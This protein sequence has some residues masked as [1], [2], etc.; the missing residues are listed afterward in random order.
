MGLRES[1][2]KLV[3]RWVFTII[4]FAFAVIV[5]VLFVIYDIGSGLS[6]RENFESQIILLILINIIVPALISI[7]EQ[8]LRLETLTNKPAVETLTSEKYV[9]AVQEQLKKC[10]SNAWSTFSLDGPVRVE[11]KSERV[12][13]NNMVK[14]NKLN[15]SWYVTLFDNEKNDHGRRRKGIALLYRIVEDFDANMTSDGGNRCVDGSMI[16]QVQILK[17]YVALIDYAV[18]DDGKEVILVFPQQRGDHYGGC[19]RFESPNFNQY[20]NGIISGEFKAIYENNTFDKEYL[21]QI[22]E[23]FKIKDINAKDTTALLGELNADRADKGEMSQKI[24]Q[25]INDT[26][27]FLSDHNVKKQRD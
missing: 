18:G 1:L 9:K 2:A 22:I 25:L 21:N 23:L 7:A 20:K 11:G 15:Y 17:S 5:D 24:F 14:D 13:I 6:F 4:A 27:N 19:L 8:M 16:L 12:L 10:K 3:Y 26:D